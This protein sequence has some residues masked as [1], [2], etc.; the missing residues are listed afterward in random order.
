MPAKDK[1]VDPAAEKKKEDAKKLSKKGKKTEE[2]EIEQMSLEDQ[3]LKEKLELLVERMQDESPDIGRTALEQLCGEI[4]TSTS[5]M[6]SVPKPLKFLLSHYAGIQLFY[7]KVT[8]A[9]RKME[10]ADLLSVLAMTS[11]DGVEGEAPLSSKSAPKQAGGKGKEKDGEGDKKAAAAE[12]PADPADKPAPPKRPKH[13]VLRFRL[14]SHKEF[15][16]WGHQYVRHLASQIGEEVETRRVAAG[17]EEK[18]KD[19]LPEDQVLSLVPDIVKYYMEA[20]SEPEAVDILLEVAKIRDIIGHLQKHNYEKT[21]LYLTQCGGFLPYPVDEEIFTLCY[22]IYFKFEDFINSL[23]MAMRLD[24]QERVNEV[25]EKTKADKIMRRQLG[26]LLGWQQFPYGLEEDDDDEEM[27]GDDDNSDDDDDDEEKEVL[28]EIISNQ[29]LSEAYHALAMDLDVIEPKHPDDIYKDFEQT[30]VVSA[31]KN[32]AS[33]YVNAFVNAGFGKDKLM[34][35]KDAASWIFQN[36]D[37]GIMASV[38]SL[39]MLMLWDADSVN[40]I[41]KYLDHTD[42]YVKA[43]ARLAVG[44][45][46]AGMR[47]E[48]NVALA[49]LGDSVEGKNRDERVAAIFGLGLAYAGQAK[50]DIL[51]SLIGLVSAEESDEISAIA[52]LALGMVFVGTRNEEVTGMILTDLIERGEKKPESLKSPI[53]HFHA[54]GLAMLYMG[55][56]DMFEATLELA[57]EGLSA[58]APDLCR[59]LSTC[60]EAC[61]FVGTGNVLKI[62]N[63]LGIAGEHVEEEEKKKE[64][65]KKTEEKKS[66]EKKDD[67]DEEKKD[68]KPPVYYQMMAV[69][70]VSMVAL[71]E[72][73]GQEMVL[74]MFNHLIQYGEPSVKRAVPLALALVSISNPDMV[75][76]DILSKLSHDHDN[77]TAQAAILGL[78]LISAGTNNSRV[79]TM[80]RQLTEYYAKEP[81]HLFVTRVSQG[82]LHMGKGLLTLSPHHSD[83]FLLSKVAMSGILACLVACFD[84]EN[85][86]FKHRHYFFYSLVCAMKPRMLVTLDEELKQINVAVRVGKAL[87][88]VA[89]AGKR[90]RITGFQ[91]HDTPVLLAHGQRAELA[92]EQYLSMTPVLEGFAILKTNPEWEEEQ[93]RLAKKKAEKE[94][95]EK[96][97]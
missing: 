36:K 80:L 43:G 87:D 1:V 4:R 34:T 52:A 18:L 46:C 77:L 28:E 42:N 54:L 3:A 30:S 53:F 71:G 31:R 14:A 64:E 91:Q 63:F 12:K 49:V 51:T 84:M 55:N 48:T 69:L 24:S 21:C 20:Q 60:M 79:S 38:A 13:D 58:F 72:E 92:T 93:K 6:T 67:D 76:S 57:E 2:D 27:E 16:P 23:R 29:K 82:L 88:V 94:T 7:D 32:L 33:C 8:D 50:E 65:E 26:Y 35:T 86:I 11:A 19:L 83:R 66:E 9:K 45:A 78:G 97:D 5:S 85:N 62:Q 96:K 81:N 90:K 37:H 25:M 74:R 39:G 61:A 47:S 89:Q 44:V 59:F 40:E 17:D 22:D 95:E 70:G 73:I 10:V 56:G 68:N 41:D 75:V 15:A